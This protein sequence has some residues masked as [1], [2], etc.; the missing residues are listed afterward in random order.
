MN[1]ASQLGGAGG[2]GGI[3]LTW[4]PPLA[5]FGTLIAHRPGPDAPENLN[6][7]VPIYPADNPDGR[8]YNVPQ[9][10]PGVN[11]LFRGTYSV[12]LMNFTW[13]NPTASRQVTV[14]IYQYEYINGPVW[15]TQLTRNI[16]PSTDI[17]NGLIIMGEVTLPV[18]DM[19][20]SNLS[21]YYAVSVN[22]TDQNDQFLDLL[23]LDTQGQTVIINIPPGNAYT[24]FF[25][26]EPNS[27]RDL[28]RIMGSNLD[29][30]Q[31]ISVLDSCII[32]G[33]PFYLLPGDNVFL[34]YSPTGAPNLGVSYLPRWYSDRI[35]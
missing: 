9:A 30:S 26:D 25:L 28:G 13:D 10:I 4:T 3:V 6:P 23:F 11:S 12:V 14:S 1:T 22:D 2:P 31:G 19:D 24:N 35:S 29:R 27:D 17:T 8:Q 21:G 7:C 5:P 32:S 18:K 33:G 15:T 34:A 16:T 20:P